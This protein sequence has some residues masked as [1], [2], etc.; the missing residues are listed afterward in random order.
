MCV[1][2]IEGRTVMLVIR[3]LNHNAPGP[4]RPD[5]GVGSNPLSPILSCT[6]KICSV[7]EICWHRSMSFNSRCTLGDSTQASCVSVSSHDPDSRDQNNK[8]QHRPPSNQPNTSSKWQGSNTHITSWDEV[9]YERRRGYC[10]HFYIYQTQ[11][12]L[13]Y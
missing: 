8:P 3:K 9:R 5:V 2:W 13:M 10:A 7:Y 6:C 4:K 1:R 11:R 12:W